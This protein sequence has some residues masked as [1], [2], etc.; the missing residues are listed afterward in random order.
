MQKK[1]FKISDYQ[2]TNFSSSEEIALFNFSKLAYK[3]FQPIFYE[4]MNKVVFKE[5]YSTEYMNILLGDWIYR[6]IQILVEREASFENFIDGDIRLLSKKF[7]ST[8]CF[9]VPQSSN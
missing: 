4:C 5:S 7:L 9:Y 8:Q 6:F 3:K 2:F 1:N